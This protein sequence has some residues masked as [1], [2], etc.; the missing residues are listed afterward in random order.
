MNMHRV[1]LLV[2]LVAGAFA[3][4]PVRAADESGMW[5]T[6]TIE[7]YGKIHPLPKGAYQPNVHAT[8]KIVFAMTAAPKTPQ[9]INPAIERVARAVNLYVSAGVPLNHLKFVAVAY[10]AAT[11]IALDDAHYKAA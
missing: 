5:S 6:P 9:D 10:G 11:S 3:V 2:V 1:A 7:G 8:Y 4:G